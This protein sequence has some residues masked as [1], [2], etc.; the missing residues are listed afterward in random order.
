[1]KFHYELSGHIYLDTIDFT[2]L[3]DV[4]E[5]ISDKAHEYLT[6]IVDIDTVN[7]ANWAIEYA[8]GLEDLINPKLEVTIV[9]CGEGYYCGATKEFSG[10]LCDR[11]EYVDLTCYKYNGSIV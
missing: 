5:Y 9:A 10:P 6:N 1:M 2:E 4:L 3:D 7:K 11:G 8:E